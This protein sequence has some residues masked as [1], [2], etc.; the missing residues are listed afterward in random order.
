LHHLQDGGG[1]VDEPWETPDPDAVDDSLK[2]LLITWSPDSPVQACW[3]HYLEVDPT[4]QQ[5]MRGHQMIALARYARQPITSWEGRDV[6]E[7]K[8]WYQQLKELMDAENETGK[9]IEDR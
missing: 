7:L 1:W 6:S 4:A 5:K 3:H 9:M 8:F 2:E